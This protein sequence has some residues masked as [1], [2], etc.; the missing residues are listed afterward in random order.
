MICNKLSEQ[1]DTL[2]RP[3][4]DAVASV[5]SE[6]NSVKSTLNSISFSPEEE[7]TGAVSGLE[8]DVRDNI[9][10][11]N[12]EDIQETI[13]FINQCSFLQG[14]ELLKNP[15]ALMKSATNSIIE[16]T[17]GLVG[18]L[19]ETLPEFNAGEIIGGIL[20][21]FTGFDLNLPGAL[22]LG[23]I[24]RT[25]DEIINCI[26]GRCGPDYSDRVSTMTDEL[27]GLFD[28]LTAIDNPLDPNYGEFDLEGIYDSINLTFD[29][30]AQIGKV[31]DAI[32]S[33]KTDAVDAV[34][35]SVN[36]IKSAARSVGGIF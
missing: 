8:S 2:T 24:L 35:S 4:K 16:T 26:A 1:F 15:V 14:D 23:N 3:A 27:Q 21:K 34:N 13:D 7:I 17:S 18:D 19:A 11:P 28:D 30:K 25:A 36:S 31:T 29:E 32:Q 33:A 22:D 20:D 6:V 10:D 9:P 12:D 5:K